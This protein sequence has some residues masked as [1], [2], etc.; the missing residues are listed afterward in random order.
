M[1]KRTPVVAYDTC[2]VQPFDVNDISIPEYV[3]CFLASDDVTLFCP[4][5][6]EGGAY[7]CDER[8]GVMTSPT[9]WV[10]ILGLFIIV[11]LLAYK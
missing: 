8:G 5:C 1:E 3:D 9:T 10:G 2:W 11:I 7:T 6:V 4:K